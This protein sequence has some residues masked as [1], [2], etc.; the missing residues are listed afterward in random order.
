MNINN[1]VDIALNWVLPFLL[2]L[3]SSVLLDYLRN[4]IEENKNKKFIK[5]YLSNSIFK[6]IPELKKSYKKVRTRINDFSKGH[7]E[8]PVFE[9][10]N[11]NVLNGIEPSK[12]YGMF[13]KKYV[14]LNEIIT[15][16]EYLSE[17][18]PIQVDRRYFGYINDHLISKDKVGDLDHEKTCPNCIS[19]RN[20]IN[21][22]IDL[23]IRELNKL[24]EKIID[25]TN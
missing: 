17:N 22:V 13:G 2:G 4:T 7:L 21:E 8:I 10:F 20:L 3:F 23:R 16:I 6:E 1:T 18:L 24:H 14:V 12:Y 15:A 19:H 11:A 25:L 5:F 9:G